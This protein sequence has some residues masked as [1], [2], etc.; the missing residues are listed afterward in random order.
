[1]SAWRFLFRTKKKRI[2]PKATVLL[3]C[4]TLT[5]FDFNSATLLYN[6][7]LSQLQTQHLSVF[8]EPVLHWFPG[9]MHELNK[10]LTN[11]HCILYESC[12][13]FLKIIN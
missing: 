2:T 3:P 9:S 6:D 1:M 4:R 13:K 10:T 11:V 8:F 7:F 5:S 12:F